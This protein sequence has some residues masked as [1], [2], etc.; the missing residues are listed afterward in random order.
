MHDVRLLSVKHFTFR[1]IYRARGWAYM[2]SDLTSV[3]ELWLLF[4][5][6]IQEGIKFIPFKNSKTKE[7]CPWVRGQ[8]KRKVRRR[9]KAFKNSKRTDRESDKLKFQKLKH[10]VQRDLRRAY[11]QYVEELIIS[12]E[13]DKDQGSMK[14]FYR[15]IKHKKMDYNGVSPLKVDG[16]WWLIQRWKLKLWTSSSSLYLPETE[17]KPA[18]AQPRF[19]SMPPIHISASGVLKLLQQLNPTKASGPFMFGRGATENA[20]PVK[21]NTMKMTDQIAALEFARPGK[22]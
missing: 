21:C 22:W 7:S 4:K 1:L 13:A 20:S 8:L 6:K 17:F 2:P 15:F 18:Q 12:N 16:N 3:E 9:D 19:P 14:R 10:E 11:W 5:C